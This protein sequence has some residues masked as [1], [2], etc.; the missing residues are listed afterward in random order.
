MIKYLLLIFFMILS[1]NVMAVP[2]FSSINYQL[3]APPTT[4]N[5]TAMYDFMYQIY[6]RWMD[7]Q[8][9]TQEP[10]GNI[11][12]N[13]GSVLIYNNNGTYYLAVETSD[14]SG[15]TWVG[16]KLGAV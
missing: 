16:V 12:Q 11:T 10:N 3:Q 14:P 9:T 2:I 5:P 8:V 4:N 15:S 1:V 7:I 13:R 6:Q